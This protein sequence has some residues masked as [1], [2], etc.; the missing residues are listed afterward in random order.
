MVVFEGLLVSFLLIIIFSE[1]LFYFQTVTDRLLEHWNAL[2]LFFQ[3][4]ALEDNLPNA[5]LILRDAV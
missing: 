4:S 2:T 5:T 3:A 1:V